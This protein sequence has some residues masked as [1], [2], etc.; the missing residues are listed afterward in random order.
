MPAV[1][2]C[3]P[4][5]V[6]QRFGRAADLIQ[7]IPDGA[8]PTAYDTARLAA[9]IRAGSELFASYANV[10]V[11]VQALAAAIAAGTVTEWPYFAVDGSAWLT[12]GLIWDSG[13]SGQAKPE[14]VKEREKYVRDVLCVKMAR[15]EISLGAPTQYPGT[16]QLQTRVDADPSR[17]RMLR[18][19]W[20]GTGGYG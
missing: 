17:T 3:T 1:S 11:D 10:Q 12:V 7:C 9:L 5:D 13:T 19:A 8:D 20:R 15:R 6:I 18:G 4:A 2:I 16:N 14:N